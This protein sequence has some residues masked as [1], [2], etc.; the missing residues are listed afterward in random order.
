MNISELKPEIE[1]ILAEELPK[2]FT[3]AK[4]KSEYVYSNESPRDCIYIGMACSELEINRIKD[5]FPQYCLLKLSSKGVLTPITLGGCGGHYI[6][7]IPNKADPKE[8]YLAI[9]GYKISFRQPKE[10]DPE[11]ILRAIRKFCQN[12]KEALKTNLDRLMYK[13]RICMYNKEGI[14]Y[15]YLLS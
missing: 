8:C 4:L 6:D 3:F 1:K 9:K 14:D 13:D 2:F 5:Q 12:Y 11:A 7:L 10:G 15:N